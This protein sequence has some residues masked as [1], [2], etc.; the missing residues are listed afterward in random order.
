MKSSD[1]KEFEMEDNQREEDVYTK[2]GREK[3][4][5]DSEISDLE[6]GFMEGA[7]NAGSGAKCRNCG[8]ILIDADSV[9][10]KEID[11]EDMKFCSD[12]C[13][14]SFEQR[15]KGKWQKKGR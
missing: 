2:E 7:A 1:R 8:K 3:L 6:E 14:E 5:E 13:S 9:V 15:R 4:V 12:H 10:E 11:D